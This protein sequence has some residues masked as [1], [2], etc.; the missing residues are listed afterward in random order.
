MTMLYERQVVYGVCCFLIRKGFRITKR[1]ETTEH[2]EDIQAL[3]P[4]RKRKVTIEAKGATKK[5]KARRKAKTETP[6]QN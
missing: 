2:G 6:A 3:T 1:A 5:R 4:D